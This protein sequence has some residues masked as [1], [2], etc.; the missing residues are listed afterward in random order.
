MAFAFQIQIAWAKRLS[1]C[2]GAPCR[3]QKKPSM[4][5]ASSACGLRGGGRLE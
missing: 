3:L 1:F 4:R 5:Q 2:T